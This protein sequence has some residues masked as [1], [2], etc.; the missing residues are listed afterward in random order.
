MVSAVLLSLLLLANAFAQSTQHIA[1]LYPELDEPYRSVFDQIMKGIEQRAKGQ[2]VRMVITASS[3]AQEIKASLQRQNLR[4]VI[5]LGRAG[6]KLSKQLEELGIH[7]VIGAVVTVPEAEV[8]D[9]TV[10]SLAPDPVALLARLVHIS[11]E[12]KRIFIVYDPSQN[13]WM[14]RLAHIAAAARGIELLAMEANDQRSALQ[15]YQNILA[16]MDSGKDAL[17]LPLDT[18]TVNEATVLPLVLLAAWT[19]KLV[20]FSSNLAHVRRGALFSLYPDNLAVGQHL[21]ELVQQQLQTGSYKPGSVLPL[22]DALL[23]INTRTAAHLDMEV[24]RVQVG[25]QW[26]FPE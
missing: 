4:S 3:P 8:R 1:V 23:A 16:T 7:M 24:A 25:A 10:V 21:A 26:V 17:W 6:L 13:R 20:V 15:H 2:V 12:T 14:V 11:P 22:R 18:T 5:V 19:R 9:L